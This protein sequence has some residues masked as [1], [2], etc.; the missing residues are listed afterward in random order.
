VSRV[1]RL[2][3]ADQRAFEATCALA[4]HEVAHPVDFEMY[5]RIMDPER[6]FA[7]REDGE[8]VATGATLTRE[9]T[10]PGGTVRMAGISAIGV[11]AGH[12]RRGHLTAV[13]R[14]LLDDARAAGEP[15]ATLW[16]SEGAI[17]GRFGFGIATR[18]V[19]YDLQTDRVALRRDVALPQTPPRVGLPTGELLEG[20]RAVHE[21]ARSVTPGMLDRPGGWWGKR[22][23]DPE[24]R[25][26]GAGPLRAAVQPGPDG[27]PAGYAL[28]SA[29]SG[30]DDHGPAG[31]VSVREL[32]G[33]S[34]EA[35]AGLWRFLLGLDLVRTLQWRI[36]PDHDP[37]SH[38]LTGNDAVNRRAGDGLFV[39]LLD[40]EAALSARTYATPLDVV[41]D[42]A[43]PFEPAS[44]GRYRLRD[45][46]CVRTD[47]EPDLELGAEE[48][49]AIYLGG[50]PVAALAAAGRI[51]ERRPGALLEAATAFRSAVEPWCPE[52]F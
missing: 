43:D 9:L 52:I 17:Y 46:T 25:R 13:M 42:V 32:V 4:F 18:A 38:L 1:E 39:R 16:A 27:A 35:R 47:D 23:H 51:R 44:A 5:Q 12:T 29:K 19:R 45:G 7:V 26:D 28:F 33:E 15:V 6:T 37:L 24:H 2:T 40:V 22:V 10:V 30:W 50:T 20:M 48:L 34:P 21:R 41:I 31:S 36:A 49:G 8:M 3:A 14:A 11:L